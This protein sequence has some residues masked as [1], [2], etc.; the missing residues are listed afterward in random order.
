[1]DPDELQNL[2]DQAG[3]EQFEMDSNTS[4]T[5]TCALCGDMSGELIANTF[6]DNIASPEIS[7]PNNDIGI[8]PTLGSPS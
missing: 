2:L 4:I 5:D 7:T 6:P 1:M 3:I 8:T